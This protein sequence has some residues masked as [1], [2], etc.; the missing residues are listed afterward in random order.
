MRMIGIY[1][2]IEDNAIFY[3][4]TGKLCRDSL[5]F[6]EINIQHGHRKYVVYD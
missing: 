5:L 2:H 3:Y 4:S 1:G 6:D